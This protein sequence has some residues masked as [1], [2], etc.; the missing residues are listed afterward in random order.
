MCVFENV[1]LHTDTMPLPLSV[2]VKNTLHQH[3]DTRPVPAPLCVYNNALYWHTQMPC[4]FL[5]LPVHEKY[6]FSF[7]GA[8]P[9]APCLPSKGVVLVFCWFRYVCFAQSGYTALHLAVEHCKPQV[10]QV[11]LGYGAQIDLKGGP[12]SGNQFPSQL[13]NLP[14]CPLNNHG[15]G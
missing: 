9:L 1:L 11:L 5:P 4:Y 7:Y 3:M 12:V 13:Q 10:V 8:V 14:N 15:C 2:S 6:V